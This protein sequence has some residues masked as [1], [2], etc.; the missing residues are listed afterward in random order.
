MS[1][2]GL[3]RKKV[4]QTLG[5]HIPAELLRGRPVHPRFSLAA[6]R[7]RAEANRLS[8]RP[9][10]LAVA[11]GPYAGEGFDCPALDTLFLAAPVAQKGRLVQ[12]AGHISRPYDGKT[13]AE[14]HDYHDESPARRLRKS[15]S[16]ATR[17]DSFVSFELRYAGSEEGHDGDDSPSGSGVPAA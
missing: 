14:V 1:R 8:R 6:A 7:V 12:Y 17:A 2:N 5:W 11:T 3:K 4:T 16:D 13:T 10:L 9:A 15:R